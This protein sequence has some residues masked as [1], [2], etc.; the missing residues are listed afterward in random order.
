MKIATYPLR[1]GFKFQPPGLFLVVKGIKLQTLG[2][3]R[4]TLPV[5]L[6]YS[7]MVI[8]RQ[9]QIPYGL[10]WKEGLQTNR[11]FIGRLRYSKPICHRENGGTLGMV[12][13]I[14]NPIYTLY[15]VGIILGPNP[16]LK[17]FLGITIF[18]MNLLWACLT[19]VPCPILDALMLRDILESKF[20]CNN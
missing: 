3:F 2:G 12:P 1:L 17:G 8:H 6:F 5:L 16:L 10:F 4:N 20:H 18:P 13:V 7:R 14:S 9:S 15:H 19:V 11:H